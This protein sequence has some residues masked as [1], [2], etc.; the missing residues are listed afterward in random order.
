MAI[1][2]ALSLYA[3]AV[4]SADSGTMQDYQIVDSN[5]PG[6]EVGTMLDKLPD[7]AALPEG[8]YVRVL[9]QSRTILIEGQKKPD[10]DPGGTRDLPSQRE[11]LPR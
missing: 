11:Q 5:L 1:M 7:P 4:M 9:H 2:S 10:R 8:R 6:Y 3:P